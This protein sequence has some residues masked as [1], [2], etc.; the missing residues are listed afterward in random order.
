MLGSNTDKVF[1]CLDWATLKSRR[2]EKYMVLMYDLKNGNLPVYVRNVFDSYRNRNP[3]PRLRHQ[4]D[5]RIP[6]GI[7]HN[8]VNRL[9][10]KFIKGN[11]Y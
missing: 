8:S 1:K 11:N 7:S 5:F 9:I 10:H 4:S 3:D 2:V 6:A